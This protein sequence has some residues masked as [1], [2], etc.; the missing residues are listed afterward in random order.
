LKEWKSKNEC[1]KYT[2]KSAV[3]DAVFRGEKITPQKVRLGGKGRHG[4]DLG[5]LREHKCDLLLEGTWE[6]GGKGFSTRKDENTRA[7]PSSSIDGGGKRGSH[8]NLS[9]RGEKYTANVYVGDTKR[10][11]RQ[12]FVGRRSQPSYAAEKGKGKKS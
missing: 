3:V 11:G 4:E 7:Q 1:R 6:R 5:P 9:C 2:T 12:I 8:R 10:T